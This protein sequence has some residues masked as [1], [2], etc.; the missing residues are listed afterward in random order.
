MPLHCW[1][2]REEVDEKWRAEVYLVTE[3]EPGQ[4]CLL[5]AGHDGPHEW[6]PD[7]RITVSFPRHLPDCNPELGCMKECPVAPLPEKERR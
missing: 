2:G 1:A 5:P 6:T 3:E 4:T 7:S